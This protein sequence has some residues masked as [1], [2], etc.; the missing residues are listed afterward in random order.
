[1]IFT[2]DFVFVGDVGRPD[3]LEEAAGIEDTAIPGAK[4]M[5]KSVKRFADLPE[6]LQV[7]PAH[8]AGNA[9]G[10]ALGAVPSTTVG[11]EKRFGW[12]FHYD[13]EADFVEALLDG[14]PEAPKYFAVMK[15]VNKVGPTLTKDLPAV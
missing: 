8:G 6:F 4:E 5:Y 15:H 10:K 9:C 12:A 13:N 7:W 14:Q 11:Y 1:G 3:L 2:G